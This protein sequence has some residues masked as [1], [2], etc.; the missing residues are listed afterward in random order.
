LDDGAR[1][2]GI[3]PGERRVGLAVSDP[4]GVTAQGIAT[5]DRRAGNLLDHLDG[6]IR[7]YGVVHVVVGH[8]LSMSGRPNASSQAAESL[9][10]SIEQRFDVEVTLWDERLSSREARRAMAGTGA[11]R[12]SKGVVDR[13][14][15]VLILQGFLDSRCAGGG[16]A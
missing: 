9:A 5:F 8:P 10:R 4:L 11:A 14:A 6:I 16:S 15:A 13:V 1:I 12:R 3:D 7:E 2:L